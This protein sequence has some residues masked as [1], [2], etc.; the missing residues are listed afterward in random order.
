MI[1]IPSSCILYS[2]LLSWRH[3]IGACRFLH[4]PRACFLSG[5]SEGAVS[6]MQSTPSAA[7]PSV[8]KLVL[9]QKHVQIPPCWAL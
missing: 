2:G 8:I 4:H 1:S 9:M 3:N 5:Q 7:A 6:M